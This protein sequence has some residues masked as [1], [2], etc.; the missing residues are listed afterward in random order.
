M[1]GLGGSESIPLVDSDPSLRAFGANLLRG[2][3][4]G[5]CVIQ[6]HREML[7]L[8]RVVPTG[9]EMAGPIPTASNLPPRPQVGSS[10]GVLAWGPGHKAR[11]CSGKGLRASGLAAGAGPQLGLGAGRALSMVP[12]RVCEA[13]RRRGAREPQP[14]AHSLGYSLTACSRRRRYRRSPGRDRTRAP[15]GQRS[16]PCPRCRRGRSTWGGRGVAAAAEEEAKAAGEV[17]SAVH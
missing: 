8:G 1:P 6:T 2:E 10:D 12:A 3:R 4:L 14:P 11:A 17:G 7:G 15:R 13:G 9:T 5:T 16:H